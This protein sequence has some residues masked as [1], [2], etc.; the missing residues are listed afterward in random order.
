MVRVVKG[1][2]SL[3]EDSFEMTSKAWF[4]MTS[5]A[6]FEMAS[7][8]LF[9]MTGRSRTA[10]EKMQNELATYVIST[11]P[12]ATRDLSSRTRAR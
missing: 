9:E 11:E 7:E 1:M 2:R 3:L 5:K 12:K 6:W 10:K 4:E 8:D